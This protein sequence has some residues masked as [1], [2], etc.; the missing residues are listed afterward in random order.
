SDLIV[1][2]AMIILSVACAA[3]YSVILVAIWKDKEMISLPSYK[4]MF[5]LGLCDVAQCFPHALM[6]VCISP[7]YQGYSILTVMLS[8]NRFIQLAST[9]W[10]QTMFSPNATKVWIGV[11]C[12]VML[13]YIIALASPWAT[14]RYI[15][16][17]YQLNLY[18]T[19]NMT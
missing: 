13:V 19:I 7:F 15:P 9:R 3:A 1:G 5:V 2:I 4:F 14:M 8:V 10:E 11:A 12:G 18:A 17:F 16:E 6:G